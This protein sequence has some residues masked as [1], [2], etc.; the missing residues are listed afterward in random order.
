MSMQEEEGDHRPT[1]L[2]AYAPQKGGGKFGGNAETG[3]TAS[4]DPPRSGPEARIQE[5]R[6]R[7]LTKGLLEEDAAP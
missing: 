5:G 2:Y 6:R 4:L 1:T 3:K 7:F